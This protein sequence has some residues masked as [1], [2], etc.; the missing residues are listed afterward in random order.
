MTN[1]NLWSI[2]LEILLVDREPIEIEFS[3]KGSLKVIRNGEFESE[4]RL[5]QNPNG[6]SG[7]NRNRVFGKRAALR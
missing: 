2:Y 7:T 3:E 6:R 5:P 1:L 4:V